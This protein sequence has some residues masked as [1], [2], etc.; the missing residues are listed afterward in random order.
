MFIG[1][2]TCSELISLPLEDL[3]QDTYQYSTCK[4]G[5]SGG[6]GEGWGGGGV[7]DDGLLGKSEQTQTI[8]VVKYELHAWYGQVVLPCKQ[9]HRIIH[10]LS[11]QAIPLLIRSRLSN[12]L[13]CFH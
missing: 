4:L 7:V 13:F 1:L 2:V 3:L 11:G 10:H 6:G 12:Y 9:L 8:P 5:G